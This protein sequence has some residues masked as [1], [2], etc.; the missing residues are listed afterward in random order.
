MTLK[1]R[2]QPPRAYDPDPIEFGELPDGL[3]VLNRG[4]ALFDECAIRSGR[5]IWRRIWWRCLGRIRSWPVPRHWSTSEWLEE[6]EAEGVVAALQATGDFDPTRNVPL[7]AYIHMRVMG[8]A[9]ARYRKEW[10]YARHMS[11]QDGDLVERAGG[12]VAPI[13]TEDL[14]HALARLPENDRWL[15]DQIF[16]HRKSESELGRSLG[17]TQQAISKRKQAII[18]KLHTALFRGED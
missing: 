14:K 13:A 15:L 17:V 5:S 12:A 1:S 4:A 6:M 2:I 9:I 10:R 7:N 18:R 3:A 11:E 16:W 8:R